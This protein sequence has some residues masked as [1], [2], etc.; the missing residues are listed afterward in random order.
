MGAVASLF[1]EA[2][3]EMSKGDEL[4]EFIRDYA[5]ERGYAPSVR[6]VAAHV[7]FSSTSSAHALLRS[8][9]SQGRVEWE[10]GQPRTLRVVE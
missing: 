1:S 4:V 3:V 9:R 5:R 2:G 7:K 10:E 8:L 6:E